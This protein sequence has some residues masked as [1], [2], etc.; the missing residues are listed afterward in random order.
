MAETRQCFVS[1]IC[2]HAVSIIGL[3]WRMKKLQDH[4][5]ANH[6]VGSLIN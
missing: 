3:S 4:P 6:V 2:S 5:R 1:A